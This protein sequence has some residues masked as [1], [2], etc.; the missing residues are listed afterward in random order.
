MSA[1][2]YA[3]APLI[4][5]ALTSG[6]LAAWGMLLARP[7]RKIEEVLVGLGTALALL[8][9]GWLVWMSLLQHQVPV[10]TPGQV[11]VFLGVLIWLMHSL[12]QRRVR[13]RFFSLMPLGVLVLLLLLGTIAGLRPGAGVPETL[14]GFRSGFH[15]TLSLAGMALLLGS[16][17]FGA[18]HLVLHKQ[19]KRRSFGTWFQHLPSLQDLDRLRRTTLGAG[20]LLVTVSLASAMASMYLDPGRGGAMLSH[21]HPMLVLW[22]LITLLLAADRFR[23][24]GSRRLAVGSLVL[25]GL[26]VVLIAVSVVEIF[27][28]RF[29]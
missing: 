25:A 11:L 19:I 2:V 8:L 22:A 14:F 15:I 29:A 18:G 27:T 1:F 13:Q 23:W 4:L 24:M 5:L 20:W 12:L 17:V 3:T 6:L 10:L 28:G 7:D 16:G 21:L 9:T 26:M